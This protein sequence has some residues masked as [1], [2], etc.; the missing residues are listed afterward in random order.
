MASYA[1]ARAANGRWLLRI[2]DVDTPR[3]TKA[4][5][6]TILRQLAAYGFEVD[7]AISRQSERFWQYDSA[8]SQL[9]ATGHLF[10][11]TCTRKMLEPAARNPFGEPIYPGRCRELPVHAV[12]KS[13]LR[14]RVKDDSKASVT[15]TDRVLGSFSQNVAASIGD[16]ILRRAD[17]LYAYQLAVVVD[18]AEQ[19]VTDV[20]RG[21]DLLMNTP[22]QVYLQ[23][24]LGFATPRYLHVPL[25][26]TEAGE[27]LSKQTLATALTLDDAV[28]KLQAAWAFL[29]QPSVG[30][31]PSV[32]S[33]WNLAIPRW[34]PALMRSCAGRTNRAEGPV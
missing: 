15:F 7:G 3:C 21:D 27:K 11:C 12:A 26:K 23:R 5:E 16:F 32:A 24:R 33:F 31:T 10:A 17:G 13:A 34:N 25:V 8:L 30:H 4:A 29:Q 1:D 22:R 6:A 2:E 14:L 20:V 19:G 9:N 28:P 18:D